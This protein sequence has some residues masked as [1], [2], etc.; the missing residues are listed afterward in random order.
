[1]LNNPIKK[2]AK[3]ENGEV[4][5]NRGKIEREKND[6]LFMALISILAIIPYHP[7][8]IASVG[9]SQCSWF[10]PDYRHY[11]YHVNLFS[12]KKFNNCTHINLYQVYIMLHYAHWCSGYRLWLL[13]DGYRVQSWPVPHR[14]LTF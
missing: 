11:N 3:I 4:P 6:N 2:P 14:E 8:A 1:M 7:L 12:K 9:E 5:Q 13:F 10:D